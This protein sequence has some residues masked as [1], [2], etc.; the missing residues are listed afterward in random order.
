MSDAHHA[1]DESLCALLRGESDTRHSPKSPVFG[2]PYDDR[3][4]Y[5][6]VGPLLSRR[7]SL[8][9]RTLHPGNA[10]R[11]DS[12]ELEELAAMELAR[13]HELRQVLQSLATTGVEVLLLKGTA[14]AYSLYPAPALR[15]RTD[16]DI[17]IRSSDRDATAS[18]LSNLGYEKP[19]AVSGELLSYQCSFHKQD[20]FGVTHIL[21]VH[22]RVNNTQVF[23]RALDYEQLA[24]RALP[25][26]R[27]G[28]HARGLALD[29]AL[30]LACMHRAHH[31]HSPY[32]VHGD[33]GA[34]G[35]RLI[36]LYDIHL[37]VQAM[38]VTAFADFTQSAE[39]KGMRA[40]CAD[41]LRR[42]Q[43]CFGTRLPD[44]ALAWMTKTGPRE[45]SAAH[46]RSGNVSHLLT[47]LRSL[48][49]WRDRITLLCE[50]LI[51]PPE[52]MLTKYSVTSRARLPILYLQRGLHGAWKRMH[53]S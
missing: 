19:N 1:I 15:P 21:D 22:W 3:V 28:D 17:L 31:I 11:Q 5:H 7:R 13:Q 40:V 12:R 30:L 23:S 52:Y 42:T 8:A 18:V 27:L 41:G 46:L 25:I 14:L 45:P 26:G 48:P 10:C 35:E 44:G 50:H 49:R 34:G 9:S 16:T 51:P 29:D 6:G 37:L 47:E 38:S 43:A 36:W 24:L 39:S 32:R 33:A 4:R 53:F 2:A 20:R